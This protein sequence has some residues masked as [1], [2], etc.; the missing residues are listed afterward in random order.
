MGNNIVASN[1]IAY[2]GSDNL[3]IGI[4]E[5]GVSYQWIAHSFNSIHRLAVMMGFTSETYTE[6]G[7]SNWV[8]VPHMMFAW[9]LEQNA[10][11]RNALLLPA[12]LII[13]FA[14]MIEYLVS[15][16]VIMMCVMVGGYFMCKKSGKNV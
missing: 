13:G 15:T 1:Y 16:P 10:L 4:I 5:S 9:V 11:V 12:F 7:V 14:S 6:A 3:K 8:N 2:H